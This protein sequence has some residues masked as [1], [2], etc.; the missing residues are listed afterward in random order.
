[1]STKPIKI[2]MFKGQSQYGVLRFFV[3][4]FAQAFAQ[5][6]CEVYITDISQKDYLKNVSYLYSEIKPD[7][8]IAFNSIA[9]GYFDNK[10][11][12]DYFGVPHIALLVDH[13]IYQIYR[14]KNSGSPNLYIGCVDRTHIDFLNKKFEN[15][16]A[17]FFPHSTA[18]EDISSTIDSQRDIDLLFAGSLN[19]HAAII[20]DLKNRV[21]S[22]VFSLIVSIIEK[23]LKSDKY[24][25]HELFEESLPTILLE[26]KVNLLKI[27]QII[28]PRIDTYLRTEKRIQLIKILSDNFKI[29]IF[30]N[31]C[32]E[33]VIGSNNNVEVNPMV[34]Y[35]TLSS[36]LRRS[37]IVLNNTPSLPDGSH[38]RIFEGMKN[39]AL[40]FSDRG[41]FIEECFIGGQ[42]MM[43]YD[44]SSG[45]DAVKQKVN[46]YLEHDDIRDYIAKNGMAKTLEYHT[47][48]SRAQ[49]IMGMLK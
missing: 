48:L 39:G 44:L 43:F 18:L 34:D 25:L 35:K 28:L 21:T 24:V 23:G 9:P 4:D 32:W 22:K 1:M 12:F 6:G 19:N 2:G 15:V 3:D 7:V 11:F 20:E 47:W 49:I 13:P 26:D 29:K 36:L 14:F 40:V 33:E 8:T 46:F 41:V 17:F 16:K 37:K 31:G 27:E 38:E 10:D 42:D 30:G 45:A 5:L